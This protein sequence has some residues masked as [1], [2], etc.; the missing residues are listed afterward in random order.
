MVGSNVQPFQSTG[1]DFNHFTLRDGPLAGIEPDLQPSTQGNA[2]LSKHLHIQVGTQLC[3][4]M[5][6]LETIQHVNLST[7]V[8]QEKCQQH[9]ECTAF[10]LEKC[11]DGNMNSRECVDGNF[12]VLKLLSGMPCTEELATEHELTLEHTCALMMST[13]HSARD[14]QGCDLAGA[15][16]EGSGSLVGA[17]VKSRGVTV[18]KWTFTSLAFTVVMPLLLTGKYT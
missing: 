11:K 2:T 15:S 14:Q 6:T 5:N 8:G 12:S 7:Y 10:L 17:C 13:Y 9:P 16:T 1:Y 18:S 4:G 3:I